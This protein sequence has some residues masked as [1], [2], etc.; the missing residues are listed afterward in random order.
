[1]AVLGTTVVVLLVASAA[2]LGYQNFAARRLMETNLTV[3]ADALATNSAVALSVGDRADATETLQ[4]LSVKISIEAACLYDGNGAI[5]ATYARGRERQA[6][7]PRPEPD[8]R[9]FTADHFMVV[10]P[11]VWKNG[12]LGTLYVRND[13]SDLDAQFRGYLKISGMVLLG[14]LL[15]ASALSASL[16][17]AISRPIYALMDTAKKIAG[18]RDYSARA[19]K[20]SG[21]EFGT[22]TDGLN[23]MLGGIE[24]RDTALRSGN[25][26]LRAEIAERK[27]AE[28][29]LRESQERLRAA[30]SASGT[31][32]FRWDI[33]TNE[34]SWDDALDALFG[35][36]RGKTV[37]SLEN[38]IATVHPDDRPGVIERCE[39]CAREGADFSMEFRVVWPDGS[40]HWLDDQGKTFFDEAGRPLYM[41][42][43]CVDIT[44]RKETEEKIRKLNTS[45]EQRVEERTRE[46]QAVN[47]ALSES[48]ERVRLATEAA[49]IGVWAWDLKTNELIWDPRMFELYGLTADPQGRAVYEDWRAR[50]LP[51]DLA[52]QEAR[53]QHTVATCGRSHR[54]FRIVRASDQAMRFIQAAEM[55]VVDAEGKAARVVGINR[56]ITGRKLAEEQIFRLNADLRTRAAEL[57]AANRELEGF[58][59]S[60]SHD[61]RAP[62]RAVDGY[63]RMLIEDYA[64]QLDDEGRRKLGVVRSESQR[65]AQLIDDLLAFSRIS[66]QKTEHEAIDMHTMA[67]EVFEEL[68]AL[69]PERK[70]RL[71]L[72]P[73]PPVQGTRAMI[74]QVLVNLISNAI[75]FTKGREPGEITIGVREDG[76]GER[77]Y[78]V[79]DNGAGFDMRHAS[80][81]FGVFQRLHGQHEFA[82]TGVGLALVQRIVQRHGGRVWAE[83]EVGRGATFFFTL[84]KP[85][86]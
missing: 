74:R 61:L 28:E 14:S 73:L 27:H 79:G 72:Q 25:E 82:G 68:A 64:D 2:F 57:E 49:E 50:V 46:L 75:K 33:R 17:R 34:L 3:L 44:Q 69:D 78:F 66:R 63:S 15:L 23:Q 5:F 45:L 36:P 4:A 48:E 52:E 24:E 83:A 1:M 12:R 76:A 58:S 67:R 62:L 84:P 21:D 41:A 43:A 40:I 19:E 32:T 56:D 86:P 13:L 85:Q 11:V 65:M 8:G 22:L 31:G 38:F 26:A 16:R 59:Y 39:R 71:D 55:V 35:L 20:L 47:A 70:L 60:V 10:R 53:L 30:I 7:P 9:R 80:K 37:R 81:L 77:I 29:A 6:V 51:E 54:E 18:T 42:G